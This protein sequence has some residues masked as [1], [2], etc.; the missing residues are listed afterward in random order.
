MSKMKLVFDYRKGKVDIVADDDEIIITKPIEDW[1]KFKVREEK[2][3]CFADNL[4]VL[5]TIS[6]EF[7]QVELLKID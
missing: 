4:L 1:I 3:Y 7:I 6:Q 5:E 2:K